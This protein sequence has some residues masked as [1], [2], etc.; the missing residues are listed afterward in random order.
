MRVD[1]RLSLATDRITALRSDSHKYVYYHDDEEE[2]LYD[3][4]MIHKNYITY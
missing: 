4:K 2:T 3:L 1:T